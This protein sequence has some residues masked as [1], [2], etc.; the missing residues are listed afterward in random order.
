MDLAV[1]REVVTV[2]GMNATVHVGIATQIS[3]GIQA[4]IPDGILG[5]GFAGLSQV[6]SPPF[7]DA[8]G[9]SV[10]SFFP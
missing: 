10:R 4:L 6:T 5:L 8:I 2:A 3:E 1:Y 7:F 9:D